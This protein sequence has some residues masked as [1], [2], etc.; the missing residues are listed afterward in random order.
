MPLT[1]KQ[2]EAFHAVM[3]AGGVTR[4]AETLGV[5][6]PAI[7]RIIADL[8]TGVGF[9]LFMRSGRTLTPTARA[10]M[11]HAEVRRAF[12]GLADIEAAA[13][14]L[15]ETGEGQLKLAV[16]PAILPA[17]ADQ[18]LAPFARRHPDASMTVEV[19]ST[20]NAL[21][22]VAFRRHDLSLTFEPNQTAG[23]EEVHLG[24]AQAVCVVPA[25]HPL[26]RSDRPATPADLVATP[27][28]SYRPDAGFRAAIDAV[29]A[30]A[31]LARDLRYEARTTAAVCE[32][33]AALG[34]VSVLPVAGPDIAADARLAVIPFSPSFETSVSIFRPVEPLAPLADAFLAFA[35][36]RGLDFERYVRRAARR[37]ATT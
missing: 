10:R 26:A 6:Q 2:I 7:S 37:G 14:A 20:L 25:G 31:G 24:R 21:D 18:L 32:L 30:G 8:E 34:G 36:E 4:A 28:I 5:S 9:P 11:L 17:V 12:L 3:S 29:F 35:Q 23:L 22:P 16:V 33:V 13:A 27:F 15:R 1:V 19:L